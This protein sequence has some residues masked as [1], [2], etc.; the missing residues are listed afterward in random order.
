MIPFFLLLS[1]GTGTGTGC[2]HGI[3]TGTCTIIFSKMLD[4]YLIL[5]EYICYKPGTGHGC[6][7]D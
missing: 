4:L 6:G 7:T 3:C 1:T 5:K 2:G